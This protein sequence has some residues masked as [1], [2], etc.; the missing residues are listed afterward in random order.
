MMFFCAITADAVCLTYAYMGAAMIKVALGAPV[1]MLRT[2]AY[3]LGPFLCIHIMCLAAFEAYDFGKLRSEADVAFSALF[4]V[5]AG[6]ALSFA[7]FTAF[8]LYYNPDIQVI[9]RAVFLSA[10]LASG[11]V[12]PGWR[13]WFTRQRRRRGELS[14]RVLAVGA[15]T[16]AENAAASLERYSRSG[17]QIVGF[18]SGGEETSMREGSLGT[19]ADVPRLVKELGVEELLVIGEDLPHRPEKLLQLVEACEA[20]E[21]PVHILP[22]LY[23]AMV[24]RLEL[25]EIGGL[26]LIAL[27]HRPISLA[28][29]ALKRAMDIVGAFTGLVLG[30]PL[31]AVAA[32]AIKLDSR[33][34]VLYRQRRCGLQG[35]EFDIVKLRTMR[36]D[37]EKDSGPVWAAKDDPRVTRIGRWLRKKRID[38]MPQFWNVLKGEMSLIGPRPERP[39]FTEAFTKQT[40]LFPLRLRIRPGLTSLSH[41]LGR[42]DSD[43]MHRL[44]YD[45]AYINNASF[46]LDLR[47]LMATVKIVLVGRGAQ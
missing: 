29:G 36:V 46:R 34:P 3:A 25:Y 4:G 16:L 38:E 2:T 8:I 1:D 31:I 40:P 11:I 23:E 13:L 39:E 5:L 14:S 43:P 10:G 26:P 32:L 21:V 6:L 37:A 18:V 42:Y 15:G 44:L 22:G 12:L 30:S 7:L 17:H 35:R 24:G 47:I 19:L 28:Y 20:A 41:V 27:K 45:L 9:S 33:G